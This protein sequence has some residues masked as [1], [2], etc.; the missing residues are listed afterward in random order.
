MTT[1]K[2]ATAVGVGAGAFTRRIDGADFSLEAN[3]PRVP[4]DRAYYVLRAGEIIFRSEN[5]PEALAHYQELCQE[6]WEQQLEGDETTR[7]NAA[8]GLYS[9]DAQ[10]TRAVAILKAAGD[11]GRARR[12]GSHRLRPDGQWQDRGL[13]S[14][15]LAV[16]A[17]APGRAAPVVGPGSHPRADDTDRDAHAPVGPSSA[18][19]MYGRTGRDVDGPP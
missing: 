1:A 8:R 3:T 11:A 16:L 18:H 6:H 5:Y 13:S 9:L 17:R 19:Q 15:C 14:A 4:A 12:P 7:L 2:P 10:H